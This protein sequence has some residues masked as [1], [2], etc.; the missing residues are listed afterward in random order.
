LLK[1]GINP[2]QFLQNALVMNC[3]FFLLKGGCLESG[4]SPKSTPEA[5]K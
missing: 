1:L 2:G 5:Y 4:W 3:A